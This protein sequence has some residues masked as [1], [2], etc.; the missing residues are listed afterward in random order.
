MSSWFGL[1]R[2][3]HLRSGRGGSRSDIEVEM[4]HHLLA[5]EED[6]IAS[7]LNTEEAR[8]EA[9]R[10]FGSMEMHVK[11]C[12]PLARGPRLREWVSSVGQDLRY[13][14]RGLRRDLG[15]VSALVLTLGLGIG[16]TSAVFSLYDSLILRPPPFQ[17]PG[18]LYR[19][20]LREDGS[21]QI[22]TAVSVEE[23]FR[24]QDDADFLTSA[25]GYFPAGLVASSNDV[26]LDVVPVAVTR[27]M[28]SILG[29]DP[30]LGRTLSPADAESDA[31]P[32]VLLSFDFWQSNFGG[33][34]NILTYSLDLNGLPHQIVG[35]MPK[36]FFFPERW[37][38]GVWVPLRND[39]SIVGRISPIW[40]TRLLVQIP[41]GGSLQAIAERAGQFAAQIR[42]E[43]VGVDNWNRAELVE[44]GSLRGG[45]DRRRVFNLLL[46]AS[47][48]LLAMAL[49]N[50]VH[51]LHARG[52]ERIREISTRFLLG[53]SRSRVLR[54]LL[55]ETAVLVLLAGLVAIVIVKVVLVVMGPFVPRTLQ[56]NAFHEVAL[57]ERTLLI[58]MAL[59]MLGVLVVG[60]IPSLSLLRTSL[61]P[62]GAIQRMGRLGRRSLLM[63][64][65][66]ALSFMLLSSFALV[67]QGF[68]KLTRIDPGF[69]IGK[70]VE[71]DLRLPSSTSMAVTEQEALVDELLSR[72]RAHP[73]V[74]GVQ[75]IFGGLPPGGGLIM[76]GRGIQAEGKDPINLASMEEIYIGSFEP[77][78]LDLLGVPLLAGRDF[79][80]EEVG[81]SSSIIIDL[82][83]ARLLWGNESPLGRRLRFTG[84]DAAEERP[85]ETVVGV[86]PDL[87]LAGPDDRSA[88][89]DFIRPADPAYPNPTLVIKARNNA[90]EILAPTRE[91]VTSVGS[92][93]EV[94]NLRLAREDWAETYQQPT[95]VLFIMGGF[96]LIAMCLALTGVVAVTAFVTRQ[97]FREM[98]IRMAIGAAPSSIRRAM[99]VTV[100]RVGVMGVGLGVFGA[101]AS[102]QLL[103]SLLFET[104]P[105]D[106][107]TL[108]MAALILLVGSLGSAAW[109]IFRASE[110]PI[111]DILNSD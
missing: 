90:A 16:G 88:R 2:V 35:V 30:L 103:G 67:A 13:A 82:P 101:I 93:L 49:L 46:G 47:A 1:R 52:L 78:A 24:W 50:G 89:F 64:G 81:T 33:D 105:A 8:Q 59:S 77:G 39:G 6:L 5:L 53:A 57:E 83:T 3:L 25:G 84:D 61:D 11:D 21:N 48:I 98:A 43:G 74:E 95:M 91:I 79:H 76:F 85:W 108:A 97:G 86:I 7:G 80:P 54:Q 66:L 68:S 107:I 71:L 34:P 4:E 87:R 99:L 9:V 10:R 14:V 60:V 73:Q 45:S 100:S 32:V 75:P 42:T 28:F 109:P 15:L 94:R 51:L 38:T 62:V 92:G 19:V 69:D 31:N 40:G 111:S 37:R 104:D 29:V 12:P 56:I 26:T 55:T 72:L 17:D 27:D 20:W 70:F 63:G 106:P 41:A 102:S 44:F 23:I 65:Q 22:G 36:G 58:A 110:T 18:L 96:A